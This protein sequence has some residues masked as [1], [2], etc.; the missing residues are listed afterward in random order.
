VRAALLVSAAKKIFKLV[1]GK[2]TAAIKEFGLIFFHK[3]SPAGNFR[4]FATI[5]LPLELHKKTTPL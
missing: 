5:Q 1:R 3:K 4:V 2:A